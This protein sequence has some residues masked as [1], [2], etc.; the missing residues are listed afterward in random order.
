MAQMNKIFLKYCPSKQYM[1]NNLS[2]STG[3][4]HA[5]SDD[6]LDWWQNFWKAAGSWHWEPFLLLVGYSGISFEC[7][8]VAFPALNSGM[9][10]L[11]LCCEELGTHSDNLLLVDATGVIQF[12]NDAAHLLLGPANYL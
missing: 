9:L 1:P 7:C 8:F 4:W 12:G 10:D 6:P 5:F 2:N 11:H 3:L